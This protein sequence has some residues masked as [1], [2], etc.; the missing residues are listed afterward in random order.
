[1]LRTKVINADHHLLDTGLRRNLGPLDPTLIG[2]GAVIGA[3][4]FV[5]TGIVAATHTG[6]AIALF[7]G[8]AMA[9]VD[10][11]H[12]QPFMPFGWGGVISGASL[13]VFAYLGFDAVST[14]AEEARHPQ[15]D[16]PIGILAALAIC[17]LIYILTAG[18][19]TAVVPYSS[20]NVG[21]PVAD[22]ALRLGYPWAAG[23]VAAGA[24]AGLTR[25]MLVMYH[26]LTR[27][28]LAMSRDGFIQGDSTSCLPFHHP[29]RAIGR[30]P[31]G[32]RGKG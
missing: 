2:I 11:S 24:I 10:P 17:T 12:W 9:H 15:R 5:V 21:S 27:I 23:L 8:I 32:S 16:L 7:I 1:M 18:L 31:W 22:V 30:R 29:R 4:I 28:F 25:V 26:G 3:G 6:P 13:V 20:L 19:L 14:A